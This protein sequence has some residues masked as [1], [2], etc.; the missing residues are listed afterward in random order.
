M[1]N[2]SLM[3]TPS[4]STFTSP[5][6]SESASKSVS[7]WFL[8]LTSRSASVSPSPSCSSFSPPNLLSSLSPMGSPIRSTNPSSNQPNSS[9]VTY[10]PSPLILPSHLP[11][12]SLLPS[13]SANRIA[14]TVTT[15]ATAFLSPSSLASKSRPRSASD[16]PISS[17]SRRLGSVTNSNF[18]TQSSS[19]TVLKSTTNSPDFLPQASA[20][21][22]LSSSGPAISQEQLPTPNSGPYEVGIIPQTQP[23]PSSSI[24]PSLNSIRPT[25]VNLGNSGGANIELTNSN[26]QT[27][28][29]VRF[30]KGTFPSSGSISLTSPSGERLEQLSSSAEVASSILT[31]E[32]EPK[33]SQPRSPVEICFL[34]GNNNTKTSSSSQDCKVSVCLGCF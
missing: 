34:V 32:T 23:K 13:H 18:K 11:P 5:L 28:V 4:S 8:P 10:S 16:S 15:G 6:P 24:K 7:A 20:S 2:D 25:K 26:G 19:Q 17:A 33:G 22:S 21:N 12:V 30:P 1:T 29:T 14:T 3:P 27:L 9:S 31:I